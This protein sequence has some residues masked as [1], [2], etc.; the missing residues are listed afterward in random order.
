MIR[1]VHLQFPN[2][3]NF[4]LPSLAPVTPDSEYGVHGYDNEYEEMRAIFM[5][6]GPEFSS[7]RMLEPFDNIDLYQMLCIFLDIS[8]PPS[9]GTDRTDTWNI[10]LKN[11]VQRR[12]QR[13]RPQNVRGHGHR[14]RNAWE[15][16]RRRETVRPHQHGRRKRPARISPDAEVREIA[17]QPDK[18]RNVPNRRS[19]SRFW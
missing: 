16:N 9:E 19:E 11:G 7:G 6:K 13:R 5:G 4:L 2:N 17:I 18:I 3:H 1:P 10:L 8:C 15:P 14:R 12:G